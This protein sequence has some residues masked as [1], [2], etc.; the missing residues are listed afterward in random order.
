MDSDFTSELNPQCVWSAKYPLGI[1][2]TVL[3]KVNDRFRKDK[4]HLVQLLGKSHFSRFND[5][6]D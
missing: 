2:Y 6:K 1:P 3:R 5:Q 4:D